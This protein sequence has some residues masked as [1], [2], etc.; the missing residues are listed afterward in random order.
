V[1]VLQV[2]DA[3][4]LDQ[5]AP[6]AHELAHVHLERCICSGAMYAAQTTA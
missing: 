3:G 6:P 2:L 5:L 4:A 1:L